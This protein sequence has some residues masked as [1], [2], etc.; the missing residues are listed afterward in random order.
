[1]TAKKARL[2]RT[3]RV[4]LDYKCILSVWRVPA[5]VAAALLV[6][7]IPVDLLLSFAGARACRPPR[8]G[9]GSYMILQHAWYEAADEAFQLR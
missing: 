3:T 9:G 2:S 6:S 1:M 5:R 7:C 4:L 8:G